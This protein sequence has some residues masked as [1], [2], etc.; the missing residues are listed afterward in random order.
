MP[1]AEHEKVHFTGRVG[2]R[3][4]QRKQQFPLWP[5]TLLSPVSWGHSSERLKRQGW[6]SPAAPLRGAGGG[7]FPAHSACCS[8]VNCASGWLHFPCSRKSTFLVGLP[9]PSTHLRHMRK[10]P[11]AACTQVPAPVHQNGLH[12]STGT[13]TH[14]LLTPYVCCSSTHS[15]PHRQ[16]TSTAATEVAGGLTRALEESQS[17]P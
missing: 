6:A 12:S 4:P 11:R 15:D 2:C 16:A 1:A 7:P 5:R 17:C 3:A 13:C 9:S 14:T 10:G 8:R